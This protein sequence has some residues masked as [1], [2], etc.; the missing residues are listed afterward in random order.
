MEDSTNGTFEAIFEAEA[1]KGS[2]AC[3]G[4]SRLDFFD[5][6]RRVGGNCAG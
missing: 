1:S 2:V 3:V 5:D 6:R 4:R